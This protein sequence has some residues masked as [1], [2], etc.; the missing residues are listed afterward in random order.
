MKIF[1]TILLMMFVSACTG[2]KVF[3]TADTT[4]S[5]AATA[6]P[7][8][9]DPSFEAKAPKL[10]VITTEEEPVITTPSVVVK[11]ENSV[12][13]EASPKTQQVPEKE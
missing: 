2:D 8:A 1:T 13:G 7:A 3:K 9:S 10:T 6:T 11:P 12:D 4:T 5:P